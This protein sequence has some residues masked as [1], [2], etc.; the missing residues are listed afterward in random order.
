MTIRTHNQLK[1][2][3]LNRPDVKK[4]YEALEE[5]FRL[6]DEMLKAR[7]Q[8]GKTQDDVAKVMKTT[9]S[10]VGRLETGGGKHKHSP[11]I[12]TLR[13]YAS[14]VNCRLKIAFVQ[15]KHL[16]KVASKRVVVNSSANVVRERNPSKLSGIQNRR[17]SRREN[18]KH[19]ISGKNVAT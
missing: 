11:T 2:A 9:T 5:E 7:L 4:E 1:K 10:V 14:A 12:E 8:A 16:P 19:K 15:V 17:L 13:K 3:A 6:L 18:K